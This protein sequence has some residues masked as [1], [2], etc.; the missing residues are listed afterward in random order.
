MHPKIVDVTNSHVTTNNFG[1]NTR[2]SS[3]PTSTMSESTSPVATPVAKKA[4]KSIDV[5]A[6][7]DERV[8]RAARM[9]LS[10]PGYSVPQAMLA[11]DFT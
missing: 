3:T 10:N 7:N 8:G 1:Y 6:P 9:M 11:Q 5:C 4:R 2:Q